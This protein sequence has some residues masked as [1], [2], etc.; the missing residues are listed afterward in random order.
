MGFFV[1]SEGCG[2]RMKEENLPRT[3]APGLFNEISQQL[4]FSSCGEEGNSSDT[5]SDDCTAVCRTPRVQ[6]HRSRSNASSSPLQC[7]SPIPYASWR[8]LRLCDTPSTPK[9]NNHPAGLFPVW[10]LL[11][12]PPFPPHSPCRV[13]SPNPASLSPTLR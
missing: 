10:L 7:I 4:D 2:P 5:T 13:C 8:K 3:Q 9:A 11:I 1:C 12:N 6:R